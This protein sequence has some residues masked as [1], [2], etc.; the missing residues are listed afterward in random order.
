MIC[1]F[2]Y[3]ISRSAIWCFLNIKLY[4]DLKK[5]LIEHVSQFYILSLLAAFIS[6][7]V[8]MIAAYLFYLLRAIYANKYD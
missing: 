4:F 3:R 2:R 8:V 5:I 1:V 6:N 7:I